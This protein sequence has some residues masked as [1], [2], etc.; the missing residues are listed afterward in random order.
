[1]Y[2][3]TYSCGRSRWHHIRDLVAAA[4]GKK[5]EKGALIGTAA[6]GTLAFAYAWGKCFASFTKI[7]SVPSDN[8]SATRSR[9]GYKASQGTVTILRRKS[10]TGRS[11][12]AP[13]ATGGA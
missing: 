5:P 11:K 1:M 4:A 8:S 6:G 7:T 12:S 13:A 10:S 3:L 9:I 2:S